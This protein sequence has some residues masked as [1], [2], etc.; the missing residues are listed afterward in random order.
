MSSNDERNDESL[1]SRSSEK[2]IDYSSIT[3]AVLVLPDQVEAAPSSPPPAA[4]F[5]P[6][7][8]RDLPSDLT[9]KE[10]SLD[11]D[12]VLR[13]RND[14]TV[15]HAR[16][17]SPVPMPP[18]VRASLPTVQEVSEVEP[19]QPDPGDP[20]SVAPTE[21]PSVNRN[22]TRDQKVDLILAHK[23]GVCPNHP[24]VQTRITKGCF[25]CRVVYIPCEVCQ[26]LDKLTVER[27]GIQVEKLRRQL[28][29]TPTPVGANEQE[30]YAL[31]R[32]RE[33]PPQTYIGSS[34]SEEPTSR[35]DPPPTYVGHAEQ[36]RSV[37]NQDFREP[38]GSRAD[39]PP[40][41]FGSEVT[42]SRQLPGA[43]FRGM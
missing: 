13:R 25:F 34:S 43:T 7:E 4:A 12:E 42:G 14:I 31:N 2:L 35:E 28:P 26:S 21:Y 3:E 29:A 19:Q 39:P 37:H 17:A 16:M 15:A 23:L 9:Y 36:P 24:H 22:R 6:A 41:R 10:L 40:P 11:L 33:D 8:T 38:S 27:E 1:D 20:T 32:T 5:S 18:T 30:N